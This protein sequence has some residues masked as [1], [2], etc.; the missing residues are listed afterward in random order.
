MIGEILRFAKKYV[1]AIIVSSSLIALGV[2]FNKLFNWDMLGIFF[3]FLRNSVK[4]LDFIWDFDTSFV[5]IGKAIS[6]FMAYFTFK[7]I[8]LIKE[9]FFDK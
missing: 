9:L 8:L 2:V 6:L 7:I 5:L 4:P 1:F 3:A